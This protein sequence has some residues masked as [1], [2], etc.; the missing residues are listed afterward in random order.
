MNLPLQKKK[1]LSG[2]PHCPPPD[3]PE[4]D[5]LAL[6]AVR[7]CNGYCGAKGI[8]FMLRGRKNSKQSWLSDKPSFGAGRGGSESNW[9]ARLEVLR[10]AKLVESHGSYLCLRI[11][12]GGLR[13]LE[14][15]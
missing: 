11:T 2:F 13:R 6:E 1:K 8:T 7:D 10:R 15:P 4:D 9:R 14:E 5:R 12:E 3:S